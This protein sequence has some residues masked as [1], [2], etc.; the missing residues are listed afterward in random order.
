M[1]VLDRTRLFFTAYSGPTATVE[2]KHTKFVHFDSD[3][4]VSFSDLVEFQATINKLEVDPEKLEK[5]CT[6]FQKAVGIG[7][8]DQVATALQRRSLDDHRNQENADTKQSAPKKFVDAIA[9]AKEANDI[10]RLVKLQ[11]GMEAFG[12]EGTPEYTDVVSTIEKS[13]GKGKGK[14]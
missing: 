5:A 12:L 8:V 10:Q 7:V 2:T 3:E 11:M 4:A 6:V 13:E 14:G 9:A 1:S